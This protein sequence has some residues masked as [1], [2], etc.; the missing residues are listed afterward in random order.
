M[1]GPVAEGW[2]TGTG[3]SILIDSPAVDHRNAFNI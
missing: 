2:R 1:L 3:Y